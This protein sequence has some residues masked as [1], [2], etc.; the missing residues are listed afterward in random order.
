MKKSKAVVVK[1]VGEHLNHEIGTENEL[2]VNCRDFSENELQLI[3]PLVL[4]T[5]LVYE[6]LNTAISEAIGRKV[7][8][9][10]DT[11]N[12]LIRK[13]S[14]KDS[15]VGKESFSKYWKNEMLPILKTLY[16]KVCT[17]QVVEENNQGILESMV[18]T[19]D[20]FNLVDYD[21]ICLLEVIPCK[22]EIYNMY[23]LIAVG[24]EGKLKPL[25]GSV[26]LNGSRTLT[27]VCAYFSSYL[28]L[29]SSS[30]PQFEIVYTNIPLARI[31]NLGFGSSV[32][33][34][35]WFAKSMASKFCDKLD[36]DENTRSGH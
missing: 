20:K 16:Q 10:K 27:E 22:Q 23:L 30:L 9:K 31:C 24:N 11:Y 29:P 25:A 7:E 17:V 1:F 6:S 12:N 35:P 4:E 8:L 15:E 13:F 14:S 3:G 28:L 18:W 21:R 26:I 2:E 36:V 33:L 5:S 19:C 34:I 32:F